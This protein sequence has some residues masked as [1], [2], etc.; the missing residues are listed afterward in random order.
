MYCAGSAVDRDLS[1]VEGEGVHTDAHDDRLVAIVAD[2]L[3]S[4]MDGAAPFAQAGRAAHVVVGVDK[5]VESVVSVVALDVDTR[6]ACAELAGERIG[7]A[8][9]RV[10]RAPVLVKTVDSTLRGHVGLEVVAARC[11][12]ERRLTVVTRTVGDPRKRSRSASSSDSTA[13]SWM[14]AATPGTGRRRGCPPRAGEC[15]NPLLWPT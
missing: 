4:A 6:R 13:R 11:A 8:V 14:S 12:A 7:K 9:R 1:S 10:A 15:Q 2:D 3:T 5:P